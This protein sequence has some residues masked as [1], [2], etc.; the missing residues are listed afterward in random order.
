MDRSFDIRFWGVR[1]S[2]ACGG[3]DYAAY[4]GNTSCLEVRC[5]DRLMIFD[6]GTGIRPL[7]ERMMREMRRD[8][9]IYL[10]HTH[11]DHICGMPFFAPFFDAER[12]FEVWSGHLE[13]PLSTRDAVAS[14]MSAPVLPIDPNIFRARIDYRNFK[15]GETLDAGGGV[16]LRTVPLNHPNGATGYRIDY[17]GASACYITD[18]EHQ[19]DAPDPALLEMVRGSDLLIYDSSYTDAEYK[20]RIGFGHSTWRA[21]LTLAHRAGIPRFMPFHHDPAHTDDVMRAIE[22]EAAAAGA[23][24]GVQVVAAREGMVVSPGLALPVAA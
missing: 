22:A 16:S 17:R 12:S 1:G 19:G 8:A 6:G 2:I 13:W 5:G 24:L 18:L 3:P 4:G 15:G 7:G 23:A 14:L 11:F 10:T 20:D 21:G 9:T